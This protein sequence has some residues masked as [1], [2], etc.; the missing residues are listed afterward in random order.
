M[1]DRNI[2]PLT[3]IPQL[4][5]ADRTKFLR[6]FNAS[7]PESGFLSGMKTRGIFLKSKLSFEKL[8]RI[9]DLSDTQERGALD[10]TDFIIAMYYIQACMTY[11]NFDLPLAL[12]ASLYRSAVGT[13]LTTTAPTLSPEA[14]HPYAFNKRFEAQ[15]PTQPRE[16]PLTIAAVPVLPPEA[17]PAHRT[18][19]PPPIPTSPSDWIITPDQRRRYNEFF[20]TF[21]T[22]KSGSVHA[23]VLAPFLRA[24][25]IDRDALAQIWDLVDRQEVGHLTQEQFAAFMHLAHA[26]RAGKELP[27]T[28]PLTLTAAYLRFESQATSAPL[29]SPL[30]QSPIPPAYDS[31]ASEWQVAHHAGGAPPEPPRPSINA[32]LEEQAS[33]LSGLEQR[34]MDLAVKITE[35]CSELE[36]ATRT[37]STVQA[38]TRELRQEIGGATREATELKT[39]LDQLRQEMQQQR[40]MLDGGRRQPVHFPEADPPA[41]VPRAEPPNEF[42]TPPDYRAA[43]GPLSGADDT[44]NEKNPRANLRWLRDM[45]GRRNAAAVEPDV[46]MDDA[47]EELMQL[48]VMGFSRAD[49][50]GALQRHNYGF[51]PALDSLLQ[52]D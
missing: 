6:L 39:Q 26:N 41:D 34:R 21:D 44:A 38:K 17:G 46:G 15:G 16:R 43:G 51:Q 27:A 14:E 52:A 1:A 4:N 50:L 31:L 19:Q 8:S 49:S 37:L 11:S 48:V 12:P 13:D 47:C 29:T 36:A 7:Q 45:F 2:P 42:D 23:D 22:A 18:P 28:L 33:L 40:Q 10:S 35:A 20:D 3:E 30:S 32:V 5:S 24:S 9:W 25:D